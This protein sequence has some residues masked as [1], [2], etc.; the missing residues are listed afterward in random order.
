MSDLCG[1]KVTASV[2]LE[3]FNM[4]STWRSTGSPPRFP[5]AISGLSSS[6]CESN[7]CHRLA[8]ALASDP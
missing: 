4:L 5:Q 6:C 3:L 8:A 2:K 7:K 1:A